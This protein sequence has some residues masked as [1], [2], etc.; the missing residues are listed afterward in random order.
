[1]PDEK[2]REAPTEAMLRQFAERMAATPKEPPKE[3]KIVR[4]RIGF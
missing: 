1:M 4:K 2:K 3:L